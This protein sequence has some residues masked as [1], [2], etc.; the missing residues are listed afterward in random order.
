M[1]K[2][3]HLRYN[4]VIVSSNQYQILFQVLLEDDRVDLDIEDPDGKTLENMLP[5]DHMG[6]ARSYFLDARQRQGIR[7]GTI[8]RNKWA[9]LIIN[10]DYQK[11]TLNSLEGPR[12][13]LKL[14]EKV[15]RD[16]GYQIKIV[17]DSLD[18]F[19]DVMDW[20]V[21]EKVKESTDVFQLFFSGHG[22]HKTTAEKGIRRNYNSEKADYGQEGELGDCLVNSDGTYCEELLLSSSVSK[23]LGENAKLCFLYDMCR[24][25][26]KV[27]I[28]Y[29]CIYY[30]IF[31]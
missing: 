22:L 20:M 16:K 2:S 8:R 13:D 21:D 15:F 24:N 1:G 17:M 28:N 25:E 26:T 14:A 3:N 6:S 29:S 27:S 11:S 30:F 19:G 23:E 4:C 7:D 31:F 10:C 9:L 18:I 5:K 12:H